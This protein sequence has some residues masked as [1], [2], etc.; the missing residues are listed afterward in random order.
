MTLA[1][2]LL[3][4][5]WWLI[6][7][8]LSA[9]TVLLGVN[10]S[11]HRLH[12]EATHAAA[13]Y[14]L[15]PGAQVLPAQSQRLEPPLPERREEGAAAALG[16]HLYEIGGF[17]AVGRD[18]STVFVFD[19]RK[20]STGPPLPVG[21]DHTSAAVL[22]GRLYV[23]GG[24]AEGIASDRVFVLSVSRRSWAAAPRLRHARGA[25]SL[26]AVGTSLLAMGGKDSAGI[27]IARGELYRADSRGW[28]DITRLP[29]PRDH[30][31]GFAYGGLACVAGG[32]FPNTARVDCYDSKRRVWR[33]LA[34]LPTATSGAGAAV[35]NGEVL[36][37]GGEL[38]GESGG[39]LTQLMRL[40][41][42]RW[43]VETMQVPRHGLQFV[44]F[45][46]RVWACGGGTLPGLHA[47]ATCTSIR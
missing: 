7:V 17:D 3:A 44:A 43:T 33:R 22:R 42:A 23:A 6:T 41:R 5:V 31:A 25:L 40:V 32:R 18:T 2:S 13:A 28:R 4:V 37:G 36:V 47:V 10:A 39:V 26:I 29:V 46:G 9:V 35:L 24:F 19:G 11:G 45:R 38:A 14:S 30:G 12:W 1:R 34:D 8:S 16:S 15:L 21:V 20:W 27:E